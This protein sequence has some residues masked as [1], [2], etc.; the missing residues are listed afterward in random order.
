MLAPTISSSSTSEALTYP[1][2]LIA[3][4]AH[5]LG[6]SHCIW[7]SPWQRW[8]LMS[9]EWLVKEVVIV[10]FALTL[11]GTKDLLLSCPYDAKGV[12]LYKQ[13]IGFMKCI[14]IGNY[15]RLI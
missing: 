8:H 12:V 15:K 4:Y 7:P 9:E 10:G 13:I 3:M 6:K 5:L 11:E 2:S 1:P 14:R